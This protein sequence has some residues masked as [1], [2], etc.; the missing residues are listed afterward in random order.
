MT[1]RTNDE[2][3][4]DLLRYFYIGPEFSNVSGPFT[5]E[6][7][8]GAE[9]KE[10][11]LSLSLLARLQ[12]LKPN[13]KLHLPLPNE[14]IPEDFSLD[15]SVSTT[16]IT[17]P[18]IIRDT[19][20]MRVWF[21]KDTTY[22]VPKGNIFLLVKR[23]DDEETPPSDP[24]PFSYQ[25]P[26]HSVMT[27]M[28]TELVKDALSEYSY[29]AEI[30]GLS[31]GIDVVVEGF[32]LAFS[33]YSDKLPLLM[34][35]VLTKARYLTVDPGRFHMHKERIEKNYVNFAKEAPHRHTSFFGTFL[36][37]QYLWTPEE[38][39]AVL[40]DL[41]PRDIYHFINQ[42]YRQLHVEML[43]HGNVSQQQADAIAARIEGIFM[44]S[45]EGDFME[46]NSMEGT[47]MKDTSMKDSP[48]K[49]TTTNKTRNNPELGTFSSQPLPVDIRF[50]SARSHF[51]PYPL[52][53]VYVRPV[54]DPK[55]VNSAIEYFLQTATEESLSDRCKLMLMSHMLQDP[56]FDQLRTKEQLGYIVWTTSRRSIGV[57]GLR[58]IIQ[59]ERDT[60]H[61]EQRIE[62]FLGGYQV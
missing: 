30:A 10:M 4:T 55:N 37:Q 54:A 57:S 48:L 14:Y 19:P 29:M 40:P 23:Y 41:Q 16:E 28:F 2:E 5:K 56:A 13:P 36:F 38:K 24:S 51:L 12:E 61:L 60:V 44:K 47:P 32:V 45:M 35:R 25:T 11:A 3:E 49:D 6:K 1:R 22:L 42:F 52:S 21:K 62:S 9:Y 50:S 58:I 43:V 20:T 34:D 53:V 31:Y 17:F 59:S 18:R 26:F 33:G 46:G 8:Y 39:L 7:W 27:K 15:R